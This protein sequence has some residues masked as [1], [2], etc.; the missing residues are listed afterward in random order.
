L[1]QL[2]ENGLPERIAVNE[3]IALDV[4]EPR[5]LQRFLS[6]GLLDGQATRVARRVLAGHAAAGQRSEPV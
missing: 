5:D 1:S 6:H 4:D 3:N 2:A